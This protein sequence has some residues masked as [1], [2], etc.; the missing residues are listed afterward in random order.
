MKSVEALA[1]DQEL[2]GRRAAVRMGRDVYSSIPPADPAVK[3]T[4][5]FTL[6]QLSPPAKR[7]RA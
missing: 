4:G 2:T 6:A 5:T 7:R 1:A 3:A